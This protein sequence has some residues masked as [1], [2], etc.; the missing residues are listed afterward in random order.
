[1]GS[2][3]QT[4]A[5]VSTGGVSGQATSAPSST[6]APSASSG[7]I[8][9]QSGSSSTGATGQ[10]TTGSQSGAMAGDDQLQQQIQTA[11][12]NDPSLSNSTIMVSLA[13]DSIELSGDVATGKEKKTAQRIAESYAGNRK[14]KNNITVAGKGAGAKDST[15]P[16]ATPKSEEKPPKN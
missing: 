15:N 8:G 13:T 16:S 14:M 6:D 3:A 1:M 11:L 4:G 9:A 12:K 7:S 5:S 2:Q 10:S